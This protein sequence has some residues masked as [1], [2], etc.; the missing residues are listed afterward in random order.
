MEEAEKRFLKTTCS[1]FGINLQFLNGYLKPTFFNGVYLTYTFKAYSDLGKKYCNLF[2]HIGY[3]VILS[4]VDQTNLTIL[5]RDND[6]QMICSEPSHYSVP[7][8]LSCLSSSNEDRVV[9]IVPVQS[10]YHELKRFLSQYENEF[11]QPHSN[12]GLFVGDVLK[13]QLV[14]VLLCGDQD[15]INLKNASLNL[16]HRYQSSY[17]FNLF[18]FYLINT[19]KNS[20]SR[21][22]GKSSICFAI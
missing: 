1:K 11:F 6:Y 18:R 21:G 17:G 9:L 12:R 14:I 10:R 16:L 5:P 3:G 22:A 2:L 13:V 8:T 7:P 20:F 4:D 15:N 19:K